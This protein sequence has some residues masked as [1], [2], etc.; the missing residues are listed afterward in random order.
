MKPELFGGRI[1]AHSPMGGL[2]L[3]LRKS[4]A[5]F[6][7]REE[8]YLRADPELAAK[9][10][11]RIAT[12]GR[13]LVG[14]S[15]R[16]LHREWGANKTAKLSDFEAIL[17]WPN[18]RFV[19]LQYGDTNEE[20]AALRE[21]GIELAHLDDI[22]NTNDIDG[23]AALITACDAVV[24]VSNTTAHLAGALGKPVWLLV[25]YGQGRLWYWFK[26]RKDSPWYPHMRVYRQVNG[27]SWAGLVASI[28]KELSEFIERPDGAD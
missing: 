10:R 2:G 3:H 12:G 8:G 18:A 16:S 9:L 1:D 23:L 26:E 19:D 28:Q 25:P 7:R 5:D 4:W 27:Q 22:D 24:S 14:L 20:R 21:T 11:Q 6:P 17:R 15:W 13:K